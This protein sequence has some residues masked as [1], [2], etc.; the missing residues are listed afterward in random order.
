VLPDGQGTLAGA[1]QGGQ[2]GLL[3]PTPTPEPAQLPAGG[4]PFSQPEDLLEQGRL[5]VRYGDYERAR[6]LPDP[7]RR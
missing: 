2:T 4:R 1:L 7:G 5:L 3:L 6:T